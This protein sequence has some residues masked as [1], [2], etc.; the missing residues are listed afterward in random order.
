MTMNSGAMLGGGRVEKKDGGK[1][2][3]KDL[4]SGD[5]K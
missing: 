2:L 4:I 3:T 1:R 5:G